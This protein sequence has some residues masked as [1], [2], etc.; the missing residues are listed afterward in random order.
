M[1]ILEMHLLP[2][3]LD[4]YISMA[5]IKDGFTLLQYSNAKKPCHK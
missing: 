1:G 2:S 3:E 4:Q 5:D